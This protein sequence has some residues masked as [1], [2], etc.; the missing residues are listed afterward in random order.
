MAPE[1]SDYDFAR[2]ECARYLRETY[3]SRLQRALE[4][5]PPADLWWQPHPDCI[6]VG[7]VLLHLEGNVRQWILSG[8]GGAPDARERSAEFLPNVI[9]ADEARRAWSRR[10]LAPWAPGGYGERRRCAHRGAL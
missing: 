2:A 3:M 7:N 4:V 10:G 5:L 1:M 9:L 8:L 6:S